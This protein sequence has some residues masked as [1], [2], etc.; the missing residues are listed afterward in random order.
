MANAIDSKGVK[1]NTNSHRGRENG[2][3]IGEDKIVA[4]IL[5]QVVGSRERYGSSCLV[6]PARAVSYCSLSIS[7]PDRATRGYEY[8]TL[9]WENLAC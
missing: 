2:H 5:V 4:V 9:N 8:L 7:K 3:H 1:T 6:C